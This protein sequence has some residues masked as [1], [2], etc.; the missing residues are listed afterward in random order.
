MSTPA[1][2]TI[3]GA[4]GK[5]TIAALVE[6]ALTAGAALMVQ[7]RA[8]PAPT[9]DTV[10]SVPRRL[11]ALPPARRA[12]LRAATRRVKARAAEPLNDRVRRA[13][14][15]G[16]V[17]VAEFRRVTRLDKRQARELVDS[18]AIVATGVTRGR[19]YALPGHSA[20]EAP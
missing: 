17:L 20:K 6:I 14:A 12:S 4:L 2:I 7:P 10:D 18:G 15:N 13:L 9:I 3:C 19:R 1:Q 16:P 8:L 11:K 5:D